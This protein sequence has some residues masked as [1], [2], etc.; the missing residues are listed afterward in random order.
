MSF[1]SSDLQIITICPICVHLLWS[2]TLGHSK[3]QRVKQGHDIFQITNAVAQ[4]RHSIVQVWSGFT[5]LSRIIAVNHF[6]KSFVKSYSV[7]YLKMTYFQTSLRMISGCHLPQNKGE[8]ILF[9]GKNS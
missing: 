1:F 8:K 9:E 3:G 4:I 5:K 2:L 6:N 7:L